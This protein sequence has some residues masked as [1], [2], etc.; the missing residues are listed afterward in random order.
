MLVGNT[1]K[2]IFANETSFDKNAKIP[3]EN[4]QFYYKTYFLFTFYSFLNLL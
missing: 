4:M 2:N 1:N 3:F